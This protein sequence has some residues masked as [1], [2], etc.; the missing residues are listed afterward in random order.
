M[1]DLGVSNAEFMDRYFEREMLVVRGSADVTGVQWAELS[2]YVS[3][4][5]PS[6]DSRI[7]VFLNGLL[8]YALYAIR[9][10]DLD[11]MR[12]A[13]DAAD[14]A[15]LMLEGA[16]LVLN[17]L[18][19]DLNDVAL[20][21]Q[22]LS[23]FLSAKV[24]ANGYVAFGG[25]GSFGK[26]WDTHDVFAIQWHGK[27][28]WRIY[29][30]TFELPLATQTSKRHKSECPKTPIFDDVLNAGDVLYI[31][32]GWWHEATPISGQETFHIAAGVH[33]ATR[34]DYLSW[35][36]SNVL[37]QQLLGRACVSKDAYDRDG[38]QQFARLVHDAIVAPE[39][40]R[41][42]CGQMS[43]LRNDFQAID[44]DRLIRKTK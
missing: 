6:D 17:R 40:T 30:P 44:F 12:Y 20:M 13:V 7:K 42:F 34:L 19:L 43:K 36:R 37:S 31:P 5:D 23:D 14:L 38:L 10:Q 3:L 29:R 16:T 18:D 25:A 1:I 2:E 21:C 15:Q 41:D 9:Y 33:V 4:L 39:H 8:P 24:V 11:E 28:R 22:S 35:L 27:K 32:R 26:H